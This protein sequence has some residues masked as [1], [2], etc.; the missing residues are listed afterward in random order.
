MGR[1]YTAC[2]DAR[3]QQAARAYTALCDVATA[4]AQRSLLSQGSPLEQPPPQQQPQQPPS[5]QQQPLA[6]GLLTNVC[7]FVIGNLFLITAALNLPA[8][9]PSLTA[10]ATFAQTMRAMNESIAVAGGVPGGAAA[11]ILLQRRLHGGSSSSA[12]ARAI[13]CRLLRLRGGRRDNDLHR[14]CPLCFASTGT[15]A[16]TF[17]A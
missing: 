10:H 2:H 4:R 15:V 12:S 6:P 8:V 3:I 17:V 7:V 11:V 9:P 1:A 13:G 16:A 5:P 14:R